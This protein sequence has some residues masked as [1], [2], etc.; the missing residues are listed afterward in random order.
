MSPP[1][2]SA[3]FS[4]AP[5]TISIETPSLKVPGSKT[6]EEKLA[7]AEEKAMKAERIAAQKEYKAIRTGRAK[8]EHEALKA[9]TRAEE[10][11]RKVEEREKK[12]KMRYAAGGSRK[13]E[14]AGLRVARNQKGEVVIIKQ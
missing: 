10:L 12:E 1:G 4:T 3:P 5:K 8:D 11:I 6:P 14:L 13:K 7:K 9:R 2:P